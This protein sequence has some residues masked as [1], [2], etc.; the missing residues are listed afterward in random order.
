MCYFDAVGVAQSEK[1]ALVWVQKAAHQK[2]PDAMNWL[3]DHSED[4]HAV[5]GVRIK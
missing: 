4:L 2:D 5:A 1:E 3:K